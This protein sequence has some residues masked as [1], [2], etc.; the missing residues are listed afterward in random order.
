MHPVQILG[1]GAGVDDQAKGLLTQKV[2][3]QVIDHPA[4]CIQHAAIQRLAGFYELGHIVRDQSRQ[5]AACSGAIDIDRQH[6]ADIEHPGLPANRMMF[7]DL[8]AI[9]DGHFPA[10]KFHHARA[11]GLVRGI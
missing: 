9:V 8:R 10:A 6:V 1:G 7:L 11:Q 4:G 5:K 2:D 3:D